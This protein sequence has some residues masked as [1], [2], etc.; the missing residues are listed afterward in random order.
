V[1]LVPA[2]LAPLFLTPYLPAFDLPHHLAIVDALVKSGDAASPYARDF[3][4]GPE[5]APFAIHYVVLRALAALVPVTI[6]AKVLVAAVVLALPLATARL[7]TVC[8]RDPLPALAAFALGYSMPLHYGLI[9]FVVAMPLLVWML[10]AACHQREWS[11]RPLRAAVVLGVLALLTFFAH[12]EAWA[13]GAAAAVVALALG[14]IP[15]RA[16]AVGVVSLVP[17]ALA[18]AAFLARTRSDPRFSGEPS[19]AAAI[20]RDRAR[21]L[22][23]NGVL[24]DLWSRLQGIPIHM[25]RG[26]TDGSDLVASR[27]FCAAIGAVVALRFLRWCV[28]RPR[29]LPRPGPA[30]GVVAVAL[31]AYLGLPHHLPHAASIYPRF[32]IV[33]ALLALLAV[34]P[35]PP[36]WSDR[37]RRL[38]AAIMT[39]VLAVQ[40][41]VVARH[42]SA[43]GRELVDF[44]EAVAAAPAGLRSGGLVF[45]P[46]ST[47][48]DIGG[49]FTGLPV[50]YVFE[51]PAPESSTW[52]YY[53]ADPQV[54]CRLREPGRAAPLPFFSYPSQ[55]N[56]R[57]ALERLDLL[58]VCGG[59]PAER[60]FGPDV[61]RVRLLGERGCWRVFVR[62]PSA[63][64]ALGDEVRVGN[65]QEIV[66]H[67]G[68]Q[69]AK[70]A[71]HQPQLCVARSDEPAAVAADQPAR[72]RTLRGDETRVDGHE[73]AAGAHTR[74]R[75]AQQ[76][77]RLR[78]V[79]VMQDA[80]RKDDVER[81]AIQDSVAH[82]LAQKPR[83][84]EARAR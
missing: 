70:H 69:I 42:Y 58:F 23:E 2:Y 46:E 80:G 53:C 65:A 40:A 13:I 78:V 12:L 4:V 11:A 15:P 64:R 38:L 56:A 35:L 36:Q 52:L 63:A 19:F 44:R 27:I 76:L 49:I 28:G 50:Y 59:P 3:V 7:L 5:L 9:G 43:F 47:V 73:P 83:A 61:T 39:L 31:V 62:E 14:A 20:I 16:R 26:F 37:S 48:M 6:A 66:A 72:R 24:G 17:S 57:L 1:A 75:E 10:S 8:G 60:L 71:L 55:F 18:C 68:T 33:F 21:E 77:Q 51:R 79:Q 74:V 54:P 41:I 32:A 45:D 34:P 67:D 81:L 82:S 84:G 25:L 29:V 22:T 30:A